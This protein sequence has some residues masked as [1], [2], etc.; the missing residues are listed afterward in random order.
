MTDEMEW[1]GRKWK[2]S[3][4]L[5]R[6]EN[7]EMEKVRITERGQV[8]REGKSIYYA[9]RFHGGKHSIPSS[10]QPT[11][12]LFRRNSPHSPWSKKGEGGWGKG[13]FLPLRLHCSLP[14]SFVRSLHLGFQMR[15]LQEQMGFLCLSRADPSPGD[16]LCRHLRQPREKRLQIPSSASSA[17]FQPSSARFP[18][19]SS[20][21]LSLPSLIITSFRW[22]NFPPAHLLTAWGHLLLKVSVIL[23]AVHLLGSWQEGPQAWEGIIWTT[24]NFF[25]FSKQSQVLSMLK[26][27]LPK[28]VLIALPLTPLP[29]HA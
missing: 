1:N 16:F 17:H 2:K 10:V 14:G 29:N 4:R 22:A 25:E 18:Y 13:F 8:K 6:N 27:D 19:R 28:K 12:P 21:S 7:R 3:E 5:W 23:L 15:N 11:T 20:T 26:S 24:T 9:I